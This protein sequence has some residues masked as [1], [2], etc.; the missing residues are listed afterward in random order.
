[1]GGAAYKQRSAS[2]L[3][4]TGEYRC[5]DLLFLLVITSGTRIHKCLVRQY[6]SGIFATEICTMGVALSL[7]VAGGFF[8]IYFDYIPN[9]LSFPGPA[10]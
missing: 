2:G 8:V 4:L 10:R 5:K 7:V 6:V 3:C 9:S 1:M